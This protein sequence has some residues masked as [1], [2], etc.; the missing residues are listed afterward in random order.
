MQLKQA[1]TPYSY[2]GSESG[3][4]PFGDD[5][6]AAFDDDDFDEEEDALLDATVEQIEGDGST[7]PNKDDIFMAEYSIQDNIAYT[8]SIAISQYAKIVTLTYAIL[9]G[10]SDGI[11]K[12]IIGCYAVVG[13]GMVIIKLDGRTNI[14]FLSYILSIVITM[15]IYSKLNSINV[16]SREDTEDSDCGYS[17]DTSSTGVSS[18]TMLDFDGNP[19]DFFQ[20]EDTGFTSDTSNIDNFN[21]DFNGDLNE[22]EYFG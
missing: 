6:G 21:D 11:I 9:G 12:K 17:E 18:A 13:I 19:V 20:Q 1:N 3:T 14:S 22:E 16:F 7:L 2:Q 5:F 4:D 15:L 8:I 10:F